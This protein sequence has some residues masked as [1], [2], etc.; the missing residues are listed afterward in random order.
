M[1]DKDIRYYIDLDLKNNKVIT[2]GSGNRHLLSQT[3]SQKNCQRVFITKGQYN[4]LLE[5]I[6]NI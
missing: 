2:H 1:E 4:K 5:T 3:L 6:N